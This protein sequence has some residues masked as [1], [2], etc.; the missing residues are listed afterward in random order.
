MSITPISSTPSADSSAPTRAS[1]PPASSTTNASGATPAKN[2]HDS[3][4]GVSVNISAT[5]SQLYAA[6]KKSE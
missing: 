2:D 3:D 6:G 1:A 5:A 4:D